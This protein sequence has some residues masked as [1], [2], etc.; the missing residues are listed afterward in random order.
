MQVPK[1]Q[2][3]PRGNRKAQ[4]AGIALTQNLP[5]ILSS[6][7]PLRQLSKI[8]ANSNRS[9]SA[10]SLRRARKIVVGL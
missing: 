8:P 6:S 4:H 3:G 1:S 5:R 10:M 9:P 2:A 7:L